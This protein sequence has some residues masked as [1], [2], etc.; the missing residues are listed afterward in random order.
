MNSVGIDKNSLTFRIQFPE[1]EVII[2]GCSLFYNVSSLDVVAK[3][4][5]KV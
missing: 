5:G 1:R 3:E 2:K 4:G